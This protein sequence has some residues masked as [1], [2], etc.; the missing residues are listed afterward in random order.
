MSRKLFHALPLAA[1][2]VTGAVLVSVFQDANAPALAQPAAA[3]DARWHVVTIER[4][5]R[6]APEGIA[7]DAILVDGNSGQ[8]WI[9]TNA[10]GLKPEWLRVPQR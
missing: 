4:S 3:P 6:G 8:T 10:E 9:M 1:A 5:S 7:R 2:A